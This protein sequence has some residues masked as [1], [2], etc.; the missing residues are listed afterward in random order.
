MLRDYQIKAIEDIERK[1]DR[2]E[3][4]CMLQ[5]PTG[6]GKTFVFCELAKR[7]F[8]TEIK[9]V[10]IL[11]HRKEL[12]KQA[13][14]S[15]GERCFKIEAG[16]KNINP[17]YD[18][19]VGMVETVNRRIDKLPAFGL[20]I[21]DEAHIG[22]FNK[23]PFFDDEDIKIV[24]VSATPT[25]SNEIKLSEKYKDLIIP[26][27][28]KHLIENN[29]LVPSDTY[30]F[31][32]ENVKKAGFKVTRTG[33]Y[34]IK[35]MS[36]FYEKTGMIDTVI[37]KYWK[38]IA[39]KKTMIF[40][41]SIEHNIKVHEAF[42]NEG[43]N[44]YYVDSL[45]PK[46]ERDNN[47]DKFINDDNGIMN[48]VGILTTGFDCPNVEAIILN[49]ATKSLALYYQ[50]IG[51]GSRIAENKEKFIILDLGNNA[52]EHGLFSQHVDWT[53]YFN[54]SEKKSD[55]DGVAPVKTCPQ[56]G[57]I[58][59]ISAKVCPSCAH[60][61]PVKTAAERRQENLIKL[62]EESPLKINVN[63]LINIGKLRGWNV[64]AYPF[65]IAE[66]L[67]NY[68]KKHADIVDDEALLTLAQPFFE[69]WCKIIGK[70][71]TQWNKDFFYNALK[72]V[73]IEKAG[74]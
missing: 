69:E 33:D 28:I 40:N 67:I 43:L 45:M 4:R 15:L 3:K 11:V 37:D 53:Y 57:F 46:E 61:F 6:A 8:L 72:K 20:I 17:N 44:S 54:H 58:T 36:Q 29:Y 52:Q 9:K 27:S 13:Y 68:Q 55:V 39:G 51:R 12:L 25:S 10:L 2:G 32:G 74:K 31:E 23:L 18:Y 38:H 19:Y 42:L 50:M 56:C 66:H 22:N 71:K 24:G 65:K 26:T 60:V 62:S 30:A 70:A 21:I 48:N 41:T 7:F 34:D 35:Q 14:E 16:I 59:H 49:R 64:Y 5:M 1:F 73:Q 47:I 63:A